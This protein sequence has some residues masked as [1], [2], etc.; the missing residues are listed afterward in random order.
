MILTDYGF[1]VSATKEISLHLED[2]EKVRRII[3]AVITIKT[4]LAF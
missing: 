4:I 1:S 2:K 3:S